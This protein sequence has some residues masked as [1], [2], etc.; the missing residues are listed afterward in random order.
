MQNLARMPKC[1]N[2][3]Q[4]T[5]M[6]LTFR[7]DKQEVSV[8]FLRLKGDLLPRFI[9][10]IIPRHLKHILNAESNNAHLLRKSERIVGQRNGE[11]QA[12]TP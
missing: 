5:N 2:R 10:R 4:V 11:Q 3:S 7:Y 1:E 9:K 8:S 6:S 12:A